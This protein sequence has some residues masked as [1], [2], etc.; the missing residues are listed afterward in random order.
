MGWLLSHLFW[1]FLRGDNLDSDP[2]LYGLVEFLTRD[3]TAAENVVL[4][5]G[6]VNLKSL[7]VDIF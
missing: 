1:S 4:G 5:L 3:Q 6:Y 2:N 7:T